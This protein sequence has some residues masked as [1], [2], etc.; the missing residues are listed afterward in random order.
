MEKRVSFE[1]KDA[2]L[3]ALLEAL[4]HPAGLSYERDGDQLKI[5]PL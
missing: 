1:V 5:S 2:D 3:T 4:L